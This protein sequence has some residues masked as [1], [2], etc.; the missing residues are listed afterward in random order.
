[1]LRNSFYDIVHRDQNVYTIRFNAKH[2]IFLGHFPERPIVPGACLVQIAED[3]TGAI[4]GH[5]VRFK[6]LRNLRFNHPVTPDQEVTVTI[7][8]TEENTFNFQFLVSNSVCAHFIAG[9]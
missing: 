2:P 1:M 3:L 4:Y 5:A 7:K 9:C 6:T 8:Q